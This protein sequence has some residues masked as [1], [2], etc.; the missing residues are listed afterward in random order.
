M[1]TQIKHISSQGDPV[2]KTY[3][4]RASGLIYDHLAGP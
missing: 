1:Q 2:T 3:K 4:N